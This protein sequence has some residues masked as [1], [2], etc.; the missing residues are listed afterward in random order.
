MIDL[1]YPSVP[2]PVE[3][4]AAGAHEMLPLVDLRGN[5]YAQA[6]RLY[7]HGGKKP[8]HPVVHLHVL[9]RNSELYLQQRSAAK[10]LLPLYWDTAVGGHISYGE[11]VVEALFREAQEELHLVDF[12]PIWLCTYEFESDAERELVSVFAAVGN[13]SI[14]PDKE[15]LEGGRFWTEPQ[16]ADALGKGILTPNFEQEYTKIKSSLFALL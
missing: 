4:E 12:N 6:S 8:L 1:I 14:T 11:Y 10:D 13:F 9:N 2:A 5:V 3:G 16:I 7:C 15:E